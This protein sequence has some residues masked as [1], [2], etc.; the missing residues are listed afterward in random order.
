MKYLRLSICTEHGTVLFEK[1]VELATVF[2]S[3]VRLC[4]SDMVVAGH[5]ERGQHYSVQVVPRHSGA[6]AAHPT[7]RTEDD[8]PPSRGWIELRIDDPAS[9]DRPV[10]FFT[11]EIRVSE[12]RL[13]YS[14]DA[15]PLEAGQQFVLNG[16]IPAL[17]RMGV[18]KVGDYFRAVYLARDDDRARFDREVVPALRQ[19]SDELIEFLAEDEPVDFPERSPSHYGAAERLGSAEPGGVSIFM[20]R[21]TR[22][23]LREE[24]RRSHEEERGGMLVGDVF[25][26]PAGGG[27]LVEVADFTVNE[28]TISNITVLKHTFETWRQNRATL[29]ERFADKR[30][31]GWYHTHLVEASVP[32]GHGGE[33]EHTRLFFSSDDVFMHQT[34]FPEPWYVALVLDPDG[35]ERFFVNRDGAIA[36]CPGYSVFDPESNGP[37]A[38][39][40]A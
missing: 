12:T 37:A 28:A 36:A 20:P 26:D 32:T 13:L 23:R 38:E 40:G 29:R 35:D 33:V 25:R 17:V 2:D 4:V 18:L 10:R 19:R 21:D 27:W 34:F 3:Y 7:V 22:V 1:D 14:V 9:L 6:P 11:V 31:V 15:V 8:S 24:A 30:V 5:V 39:A 16:V